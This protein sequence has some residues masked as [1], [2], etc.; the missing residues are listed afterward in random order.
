LLTIRVIIV[1]VVT[2][3]RVAILR[4]KR[5]STVIVF[6]IGLGVKTGM[7]SGVGERVLIWMLG[8]A[9]HQ[10]AGLVTGAGHNEL[11]R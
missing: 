5:I 3:P 10:K 4:L 1:V 8:I 6:H 2:A 11:N 9:R 7:R